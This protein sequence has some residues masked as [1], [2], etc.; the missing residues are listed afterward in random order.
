MDDFVGENGD[1]SASYAYV[2]GGETDAVERVVR[3][4]STRSGPALMFE[5]FAAAAGDPSRRERWMQASERTQAL[6]DAALNA[7]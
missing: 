3:I 7:A 5:N 1:G 4:D 2:D 6:L